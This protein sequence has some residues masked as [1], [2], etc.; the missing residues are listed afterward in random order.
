MTGAR[1]RMRSPRMVGV[2]LIV[3]IE[4]RNAMS[5]RSFDPLRADAYTETFGDA[6]ALHDAGDRTD[7]G[8]RRRPAGKNPAGKV[9]HGQ[10]V[11]PLDLVDQLFHR[12]E[13]AE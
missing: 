9:A 12:N 3:E 13:P 5:T 6:M 11:D 4:R 8:E 2:E 1:S 10:R 7:R